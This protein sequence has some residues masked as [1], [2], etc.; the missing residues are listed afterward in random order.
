MALNEIRI[1]VVNGGGSGS[2]KRE[3]T[4]EQLA[5]ETEKAENKKLAASIK[6]ITNPV[7]AT[8]DKITG[9]M[10]PTAAM[11]VA[12]GVGVGVSLVKQFINFQLSDI[13]RKNGDSNHQAII[14]KQMEIYTDALNVGTSMLGGAA[15]GAMVGG[16]IGAVI[17][18]TIGVVASAINIGFRQAERERAF[19][20]EIF[21][22]QNTR[23]YNIARA[24][25]FLTNGRDR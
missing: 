21:R 19:A 6:A 9:K 3:K 13:G 24:N 10:N 20:H 2:G 23:A 22:E 12:M 7:D 5:A 11:G 1:V 8:T 18:G 16:P 4:S 15:T 25:N 17:G 14:T